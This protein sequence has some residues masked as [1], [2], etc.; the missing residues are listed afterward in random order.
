MYGMPHTGKLAYDE[1]V[2][3]L[4]P[5]GYKPSKYTPGLWTNPATG[6]QTLVVDDFS[7]KFTSKD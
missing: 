3:H 1:L 4:A 2:T 6:L 5:Y 7:I